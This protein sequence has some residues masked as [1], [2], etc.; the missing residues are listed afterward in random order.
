[1]NRILPDV[2]SVQT[3]TPSRRQER[4]SVSR[5]CQKGGKS[6]EV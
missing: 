4:E 6:G 3:S 1:M 5:L 2:G